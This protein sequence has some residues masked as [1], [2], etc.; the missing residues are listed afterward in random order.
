MKYLSAV[1]LG[2]AL[3]GYGLAAH[4]V[5]YKN[6]AHGF[7]QGDF[8]IGASIHSATREVESDRFDATGDVDI[9][10]FSANLGIGVGPS[11]MLGLHVG[12]AEAALEDL[13][14]SDGVIAGISY[15]H[16]MAP[17]GKTQHGLLLS[18]RSASLEGEFDDTTDATQF[19]VGYAVSFAAGG[20]ANF[21]AGGVFSTLD[22]T[23]DP[24]FGEATDFNGTDNIGAFGGIE[25]QLGEK[26]MA[27]IEAHVLHES[28]FSLYLDALF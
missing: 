25:F 13:D 9:D 18:F 22:F 15:R 11:G 2:L 28:G 24:F 20:K 3:V 16:N 17:G 27:G 23:I 6:P 19:D 10:I 12:T 26:A 5:T 8:T 14:G 1:L 4:A 21:F 7:S